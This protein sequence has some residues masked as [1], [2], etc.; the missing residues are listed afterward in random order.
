MPVR[1]EDTVD[2]TIEGLGRDAALEPHGRRHPA[3]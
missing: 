2:A 1:T 3:G